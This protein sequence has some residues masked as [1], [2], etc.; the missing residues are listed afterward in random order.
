MSRY[1][2]PDNSLTSDRDEYLDSWRE[3]IEPLEKRLNC[4]CLGFD[5][6]IHMKDKNSSYH[7]HISVDIGH[8]ILG[9]KVI[10]KTNNEKTNPRELNPI[11]RKVAEI[12]K[13]DIYQSFDGVSWCIEHNGL[14]HRFWWSSKT[15]TFEDFFQEVANYFGDKNNGNY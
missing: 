9:P 6:D 12:Y 15:D 4:T 1:R 10:S 13:F 2:K 7:F 11:I 8:R 14:G 5:P 3:L